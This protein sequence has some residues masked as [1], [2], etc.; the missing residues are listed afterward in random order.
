MKF[1]AH[2]TKIN[3]FTTL[4]FVTAFL[5]LNLFLDFIL[6]HEQNREFLNGHFPDSVYKSARR[7][8]VEWNRVL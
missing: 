1:A 6:D 7:E 3:A 5:I 4:Y 2:F 8:A